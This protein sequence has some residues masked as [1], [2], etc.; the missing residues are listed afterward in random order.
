MQAIADALPF[1]TI[2]PELN[3]DE[4]DPEW[5]EQRYDPTWDVEPKWNVEASAAEPAPD[6]TRAQQAPPTEVVRPGLARTQPTEAEP[7]RV[8]AGKGA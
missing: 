1:G 7:E 3:P 4:L 2:E 8:Q 6:T 5:I